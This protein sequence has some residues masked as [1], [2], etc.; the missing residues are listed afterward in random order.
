[1]L[2]KQLKSYFDNNLNSSK[3]NF[4]QPLNVKETLGELEI[5]K[6]GYYRVAF[7]KKLYGLFLWMG[8][9]CL[10]ATV[11]LRGDSLLFT[12]KRQPNSCFVNIIVMFV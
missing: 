11:A 1:M 2:L 7:E 6:D 10:K 4:N 5:S 12:T 3:G 8:F 9:N